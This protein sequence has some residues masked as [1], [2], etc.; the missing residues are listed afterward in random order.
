MGNLHRYLV[1]CLVIC[2]SSGEGLSSNAET[3]PNKLRA[4]RAEVKMLRSSLKFRDKHIKQLQIDLAEARKRIA[5]LEG[6]EGNQAVPGSG[7][8]APAARLSLEKLGKLVE[9]QCKGTKYYYYVPKVARKRPAKKL[10]VLVLVH[11][12]SLNPE[13]Y[14]NR[15][16]DVA[17]KKGVAIIAPLFDAKTF[18]NYNRLNV[19][20]PRADLRLLDILADASAKWSLDTEKFFIYGHSAG[21]QFTHRFAMVHPS[22]VA[23]GVASCAGNYTFP[24]PK[25]SYHYGTGAIRQTEGMEFDIESFVQLSFSIIVGELDTDSKKT[26]GTNAQGANRIE[27]A[28]NFFHAMKKYAQTRNVPL[29][30][31]FALIPNVGHSS[32]RTTPWARKYLF[33]LK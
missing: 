11:G 13:V 17:E 10:S 20:G 3:A 12:R 25:V 23:K 30:L 4:L 8:T 14:A 28:K 18:P 22:R 24:D 9:Y 7:K 21:A 1:A 31:R 26:G 19:K 16:L 33:N 29:R 6:L 32:K 27:R 2:L 5:E 15:W